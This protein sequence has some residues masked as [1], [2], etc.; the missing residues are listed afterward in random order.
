MKGEY[1]S[2]TGFR[3]VKIREMCQ[4]A[5]ALIDE[6]QRVVIEVFE[7][8]F[9]I[10]SG[11][12]LYGGKAFALFGA[13]GLDDPYRFAIYEY[14]VV[15]LF[16]LLRHYIAHYHTGSSTEVDVILILNDPATCYQLPVNLIAGYLFCI[17]I[18]RCRGHG[19]QYY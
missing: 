5:C 19:L 10:S 6:A 17:L 2:G 3:V 12:L 1:L 11:L 14:Y 15:C 4:Y 8:A 16:A 7:L 18:N 9:S 13:F